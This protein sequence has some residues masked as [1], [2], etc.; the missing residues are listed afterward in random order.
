MDRLTANTAAALAIRYAAFIRAV[1]GLIDDN[2]T[3]DVADAA[4]DLK[5]IQTITGVVVMR[6]AIID[7]WVDHATGIDR[8][9]EAELLK[10]VERENEAYWNS[11]PTPDQMARAEGFTFH[12]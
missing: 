2:A 7:L 9:R 6:D 5:D 12:D 3:E 8:R 10:E 4:R 1:D 11:L